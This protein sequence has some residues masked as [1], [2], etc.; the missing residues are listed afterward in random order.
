LAWVARFFS[1]QHAKTGKNA[2]RPQNAP[3]GHKNYQHLPLQYHQKFTQIWI[4]CL[5]IY[6]LA[7]LQVV[8]RVADST[9]APFTM[10]TAHSTLLMM[11]NK[12]GGVFV[13]CRWQFY[14][15]CFR[16]WTISS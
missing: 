8:V 1:V 3:N 14:D 9:T 6:H 2:K 12:L 10:L 5:K 13:E 15:R 4:F 11:G 7:T 16:R